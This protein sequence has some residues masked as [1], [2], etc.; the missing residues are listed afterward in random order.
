MNNP[1]LLRIYFLAVFLM[2]S[3]LRSGYGQKVDQF[4]SW[5]YYSGTYQVSDRWSGNL[6]YSWSRHDFV[7]H[8]QISK[9]GLGTT[10]NV[11]KN[12]G[13]GLG[14]EWA[15]IFPYG[16]LP[17]PERRVEHRILERFYFK[18][19]IRN[20]SLSSTIEVEQFFRNGKFM[21]RVRTKVGLKF[22]LWIDP[23][24]NRKVSMSFFEQI[25]IGIGDGAPSLGQNRYY[26][27]FDL[28]LWK[29]LSI[30]LGYMNQY[31][32]IRPETIEN[33][34]TLMVGIFHKI[35]LK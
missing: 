34:H 12:L 21:Q 33:D 18:E 7:K 22:P 19:R 2:I 13:V 15:I 6:L 1:S 26:G 25:F 11:T 27:G 14:Y 28:E 4:N 17:V 30:S 24:G 32:I 5:W 29:N 23:E 35:N 31:I 20:V 9:L 10:Y 16:E 3:C 8:W